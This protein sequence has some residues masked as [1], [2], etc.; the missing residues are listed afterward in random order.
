MDMKAVWKALLICVCF[1]LCQFVA[2]FLV[3]VPTQIFLGNPQE[4]SLV[5]LMCQ[6]A[7][8]LL[9]GS[10]TLL[11]AT[12][13]GMIRWRAV[14][15][16]P[17]L[18]RTH[19]WGSILAAILFILGLNLFAE[20]VALPDNNAEMILR[21]V[22]HPVGAVAIAVFS[23]VV[24]EL[25]FREAMIADMQRQGMKPWPAIMVSALAFGLV[26]GNPAQIPFAMVMGVFFGYLYWKTGSIWLTSI[27]HILNNSLA[28]I[29]ML[30]CGPD[31]T[32]SDL[33]GLGLPVWA[34]AIVLC[35]SGMWMTRKMV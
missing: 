2:L 32:L 10:F 16:G 31:A 26:H 7:A 29:L 1:L 21:M 22:H 28:V 23:P 13:M 19:V 12:A 4:D 25:I 9:G 6:V 20:M 24:E 18:S 35:S 33:I 30:L 3:T 17:L 8:V 15:R 5:Q 14:F 27:L 34:P 11:I